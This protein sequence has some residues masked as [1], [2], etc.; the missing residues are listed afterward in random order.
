LGLAF[1]LL[2]LTA[3]DVPVHGVR[4]PFDDVLRRCAFWPAETIQLRRSIKP[5]GGSVTPIDGV[6]RIVDGVVDFLAGFFERTFLAA[7]DERHRRA[8]N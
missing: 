8:G 6:A 7:G 2:P 1:E 3:D 4:S 5:I